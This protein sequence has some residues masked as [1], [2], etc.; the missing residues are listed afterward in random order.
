MNMNL[1]LLY[2][3][4]SR[5]T[6]E[7]DLPTVVDLETRKSLKDDVIRLLYYFNAE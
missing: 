5:P 2:M 6:Q 4:G 7:F 3:T 1:V